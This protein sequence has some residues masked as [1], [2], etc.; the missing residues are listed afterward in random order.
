MVTRTA[1][2]IPGDP[3]NVGLVDA[4]EDIAFPMQA[5]GWSPADRLTWRSSIAIVGSIKHQMAKATDIIPMAR[6]TSW[7]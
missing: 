2:D 3:L 1:Q 4:N 7:F 5:A 6:S